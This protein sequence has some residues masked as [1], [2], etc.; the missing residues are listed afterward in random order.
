MELLLTPAPRPQHRR[1]SASP[2]AS[3]SVGRYFLPTPVADGARRDRRRACFLC[4]S[5]D[6]D[7]R[8]CPNEACWRCGRPGHQSKDCPQTRSNLVLCT[9]C[10]RFGHLAAEC[11]TKPSY[12]EEELLDVRC[13]ACGGRGH[14]NCALKSERALR[15]FCYNCGQ[16]G[17]FGEDCHRPGM[18][19]LTQ[20]RI[21]AGSMAIHSHGRAGFGGGPGGGFG[22][23]PRPGE[24]RSS[25]PG[26]SGS[27]GAKRPRDFREPPPRDEPQR[28]DRFFV[29]DSPGARPKGLPPH[30]PAP[31][32]APAKVH[33]VEGARARA[34]KPGKGKKRQERGSPASQP[35]VRLVT[36]KKSRKAQGKAAAEQG[37]GSAGKGKAKKSKQAASRRRVVGVR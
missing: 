27:V 3:A 12:S 36:I 24:R 30:R 14:L 5:A 29:Q 17:H 25:F 37:A 31:G 21:V 11:P 22:H 13:L 2:A 16:R 6:H 1:T 4:A 10:R 23:S 19:P 34:A 8:D 20:R 28:A 15:L 32:S 7:C 9:G 26:R 18:D 35:T 33:S